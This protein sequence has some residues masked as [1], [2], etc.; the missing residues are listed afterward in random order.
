MRVEPFDAGDDELWSFF[1]ACP[2]SVAQQTPGWRD[3]IA[4]IGV[5]EPLFLACRDGD[6][7]V[8]VL[9]AYRYEGPFG[10]ILD[11]AVQAGPL[12]GVA[13]LPD[14]DTGA[15]HGA[16][17]GA[18]VELAR[19]R[20]CALAS[21]LTNPFWPD[22]DLCAR[23]LAPDYV[24]ENRCQV[25]DLG[26][27]LDDDGELKGGSSNLKRNLRKARSGPLRIDEEQSA[28]NLEE[29]Y[30]IHA[31]RHREIGA[32]PL[33]EALFQGALRYMVPRD[34]ARFF[35]VRHADSGEMLAGGFYVHHGQV[36]D[37]L[38]PS[39]RSESAGLGPNYL[40]AFHSMRWAKQRGLRFYNWQGSPPGSGVERFKR[41]WGSCDVSYAYL[42]RVTGDAS[43][44]HASTPQAVA[45]AY[46][47][48]YALPYDQ[49][50]A[51][52]HGSVSTRDAAWT[53]ADA[54]AD[55][56]VAEP[57][58]ESVVHYYEGRLR[59]H[60]PT[61]RGMDWKDEESQK[62]RF[63][64]LCD[65]DDLSGRSV[66]EIAAGAGHLLDSL[67][68]RGIEADYSGSDLSPEM[69]KAARECHPG[70]RFEQ[71]N[72]LRESGTAESDFVLCSGLFHVK[73]GHPEAEWRI[74]VEQTLRRMYAMC[75]VGMAFNLMS[76]RVDY[77]S[78]TLYY[79]D[80]DEWVAWC[81]RELSPHVRLR[82]DYPL[83]EVTIYVHRERPAR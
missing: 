33:P 32:T 76:D 12:G 65:V 21:V 54:P 4:A 8:G 42:T 58:L 10:A 36:I 77:R 15:V 70:I 43:R 66:H 83:H 59:E 75:R 26:A 25:L 9:P 5:D 31:E 30:G 67:R 56:A 80:P 45:D 81:R 7:L 35:F 34:R 74:F 44:F 49:I 48:H 29:W 39:L 28:E 6:A 19:D 50:G 68:E 22:R 46:R 47:W 53:A 14:A 51:G 40:L 73:L 52:A 55:A 41:Q 20:D 63:S 18:F 38:M 11:S 79:S 27:A 24:L 3:V 64:I 13:V 1:D 37:A 57:L 82:A 61:A 2:T 17:L 16:L 60:G 69:V 62:L 72:V 71:R 78:E 23:H